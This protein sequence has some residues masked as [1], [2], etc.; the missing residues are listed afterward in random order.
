[1]GAAC[2]CTPGAGSVDQ[3]RKPNLR[4]ATRAHSMRLRSAVLRCTLPVL[5]L[6]SCGR[7]GP[8]V[9]PRAP[10]R[11]PV[12]FVHGWGGSPGNWERVAQRFR[13]DGWTDRELHAWGY[14]S[15]LSNA[16]IAEQ[17]KAKVEEVLSA[18]GATRVDVVSH[19][20]GG[21]SSRYY[22]KLLGGQERVDAWVSLGGPNHGTTLAAHPLCN[23]PSCV[24]MRPGSDFL[25]RL[26]ADDETPGA[27]RYATWWSPC[28]EVI[29]PDESVVLSG[30]Q[31]TRTACLGHSELLT[32]PAVYEQ[33]RGWVAPPAP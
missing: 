2:P 18:T 26:N 25:A 10:A 29:D 9:E 16:R 21:L 5:L 7:D 8:P 31:N 33:V 23:T 13:A 24:E 15:A 4:S 32:D 22:L 17:L 30:A 20:M 1:M 3:R 12:L 11:D 6:A 14:D 27:V 19:S 28:D